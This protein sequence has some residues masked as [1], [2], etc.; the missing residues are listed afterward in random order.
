[1]DAGDIEGMGDEAPLEEPG[2]E[3]EPEMGAEANW[4]KKK[5]ST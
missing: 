4:R 1:M 3:A 2:M 5:K